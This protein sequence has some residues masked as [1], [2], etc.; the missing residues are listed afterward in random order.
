MFKE[1]IINNC[2]A[3]VSAISVIVTLLIFI[4]TNKKNQKHRIIEVFNEIYSKTFALR[5]EISKEYGEFHY[6]LDTILNNEYVNIKVLDYLTEIENLSLSVMEDNFLYRIINKSTHDSDFIKKRIDSHYLKLF[7]KLSSPEL[8]KRLICLFPFIMYQ[9]QKTNNTELFSNYVRFASQIGRIK[10]HNDKKTIYV[11][12]GIRYS[13]ID[14]TEYFDEIICPF[15]KDYPASFNA[16]RANQNVNKYELTNFYAS[17]IAQ[18]NKKISQGKCTKNDTIANNYEIMLYNQKSVYELP[19]RIAKHVCCYN[20][21]DVLNVLND[22]QQMRTFLASK[23]INIVPFIVK[24]GAN[25]DYDTLKQLLNGNKFIIQ[26][27]FG[28]GGIGTF[29]ADENNFAE[30]KEKIING[31]QYLISNYLENSISVNTHVFISSK[32]T[33]VTPA[34]VQL[35]ENINNQL[36]YRGADF[37]A[38]RDLEKVVQENIRETSIVI[39]NFLRDMGYRGVAGIDFIIDQTNRIYCCEINPRF[40]S[41][42]VILNKFI[43]DREKNREKNSG[44]IEETSIYEMNKNAF[45]DTLKSSISFY[46]EVNYSCYFYYNDANMS[47]DDIKERI[48]SLEHFNTK[49]NLDSLLEY[50]KE[51]INAKSYLFNVIFNRKIAQISPDHSLWIN[52]N[53]RLVNAPSDKLDMKIALV[54]QGIRIDERTI[55]EDDNIK[56]AV[57]GG[58]DF[59]LEKYNIYIN[60]PVNTGLSVFSPFIIKKIDEEY[61]LFYLSKKISKITIEKQEIENSSTAKYLKD[62]IYISTDRMRVKLING[63]DYKSHGQGCLFCSVPYSRRHYSLS[64]LQ[65]A[66]QESMKFSFQH[67]L[68]GGGTD[69]SESSTQHLIGAVKTIRMNIPDKP[70]SLMSIPMSSDIMNELKKIGLT[71][72]AYNLEV[73]DDEIA[74]KYMPGK[75][76][77]NTQW[78]LSS[79]KN[80]VSIFGNNNVRSALIVGLEPTDSLIKAVEKLCEI[81][82]IPC[83]SVYRTITDSANSLNPTNEYL[84]DIYNRSVEIAGKYNMFIGP[85]CEYCRNNMLVI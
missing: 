30:I 12:S 16:F 15:N 80:A 45:E 17:Q 70:I 49:V 54:N 34:S 18:L 72:V 83:L 5:S 53:I 48:K 85:K 40:Q 79:L 60:S 43:V 51:Q 84:K 11:Y 10:L 65:T 82:V 56:V 71:E 2:A 21:Q 55:N 64:Q 4:I 26:S 78:Y 23:K 8:Y 22:K 39:S 58:I 74:A 73:Y 37:I 1:F 68:I 20:S 6:E 75:R 36:V 44:Y 25:I 29:L 62:I 67:I 32:N 61:Y 66:L 33:V 63:C 57:Y 14:D 47:Q 69:L 24:N 46:D 13:D 77:G 81:Q 28:G 38:F 41:S 42:S 50:S 3:L 59:Y 19:Q 52:D 27:T 35:I 9:R 76:N 31:S 7:T